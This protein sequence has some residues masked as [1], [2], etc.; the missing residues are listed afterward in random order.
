MQAATRRDEFTI[1]RTFTG[2]VF[3]REL[4]KSRRKVEYVCLVCLGVRGGCSGQLLSLTRSGR[5]YR[6]GQPLNPRLRHRRYLLAQARGVFQFRIVVKIGTEP[7][8]HLPECPCLCGGGS[9]PP[10]RGR[11][12]RRQNIAL[13]GGQIQTAHRRGGQHGEVLG[14]PDAGGLLRLQEVEQ[15]A[16]LGMVGAGWIAGRG[17]NAAVALEDRNKSLCDYGVFVHTGVIVQLETMPS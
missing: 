6:R 15:L 9:P 13:P 4:A 11:S 17:S 16:L 10:G 5:N 8:L 14:E 2:E 7:A 3:S 12:C 1:A